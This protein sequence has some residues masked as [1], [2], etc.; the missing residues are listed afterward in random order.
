LRVLQKRSRRSTGGRAAQAAAALLAGALVLLAACGGGASTTEN[1]IRPI[2]ADITIQ[3]TS[4]TSPAV[5]FEK[6]SSSG[7]LV[8]VN[9]MLRPAATDLTFNRFSFTL[10]F[11][12]TIFQ[13]GGADASM[14]PLGACTGDTT[15]ACAV[16]C[17]TDARTANMKGELHIGVDPLGSPC[18]EYTTTGAPVRLFTLGFTAASL[19]SSALR[20]G[21][22]FT[23]DCQILDDSLT[24]LMIPCLDGSALLTA[25]R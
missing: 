2:H 10:T 4:S 19:G 9:L 13:V 7:D 16:T 21:S 23:S 12:N 1:V 25:T 6:L 3:D 18:P 15:A 14:T 20:F 5:Y 11:D 17:L 8:T 24:D 22:G